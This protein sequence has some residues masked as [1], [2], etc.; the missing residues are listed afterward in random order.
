MVNRLRTMQSSDQTKSQRNP[1]PQ[2][3][4]TDEP[5]GSSAGSDETSVRGTATVL[6]RKIIA[7]P[8]THGL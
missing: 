7:Q 3:G 5:G 1:Q 8:P 4:W 2:R 6:L